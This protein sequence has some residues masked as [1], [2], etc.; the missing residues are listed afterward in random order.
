M[1]E[2][3]E[4]AQYAW[5]RSFPNDVSS[6]FGQTYFIFVSEPLTPACDRSDASRIAS[7]GLR[8]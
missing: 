5:K 7:G 6:T 3:R 4:D 2:V 1:V 8:P